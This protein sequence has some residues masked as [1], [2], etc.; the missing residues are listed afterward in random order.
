MKIFMYL[1]DVHKQVQK[2]NLGRRLTKY[3]CVAV[4]AY[5]M[6]NVLCYIYTTKLQNRKKN[7]PTNEYMNSYNCDKI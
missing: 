6:T 2:Q 5:Q 7:Y 1:I 4:D 3:C